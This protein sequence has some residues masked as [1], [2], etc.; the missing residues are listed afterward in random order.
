MM[1]LHQQ[2][3]TLK[4]TTVLLGQLADLWEQQDI[5]LAGAGTQTAGLAFGGSAPPATGSN[6]R[7]QWN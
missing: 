1:Q 5:M 4:N 7:I 2:F 6:R 3:Q